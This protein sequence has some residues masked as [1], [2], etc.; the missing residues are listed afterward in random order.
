M[1]DSSTVQPAMESS[2]F[3]SSDFVNSYKTTLQTLVTKPKEFF[4]AM[5]VKGGYGPPILFGLPGAVIFGFLGGLL[6]TTTADGG[7]GSA[8]GGIIGGPIGF[9]VGAFIIAAIVHVSSIIFADKAKGGFEGTFRT[10]AYPSGAALLVMW[11]PVVNFAAW[12]YSVY[13][14][15]V[16][17]ERVHQTTTAKAVTAVLV[18][19][20]ILIV[21]S[22][23][24]FVALGAIFALAVSSALN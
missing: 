14:T 2:E 19:V 4:A 5:P 24:A 3:N 20:G 11:I 17:I 9:V 15:I 22:V 18:P 16:G 13:L 8:V 7:V 21:L 6:G 23:I 12:A 10:I 1:E